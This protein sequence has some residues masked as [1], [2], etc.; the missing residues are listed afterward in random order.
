MSFSRRDRIIHKSLSVVNAALNRSILSRVTNRN[1]GT[2]R[3]AW[4]RSPEKY[5]ANIGDALSAVM[6]TA[7]SGRLC[8]KEP[9]RSARERLYAV[10]TIAHNAYG[11]TA[12]I[13]GTGLDAKF[14]AFDKTLGRYAAPPSTNVRVHATRGPYSRQAFVDAAIP[15]PRVYGDPV[16][17]LPSIFPA[18][19][20]KKWDLGVIVHVTEL[21]A[22]SPED[23]TRPD[24]IR[25]QIPPEFRDRVKIISTV[26]EPT[27]DAMMAKMEEITSC[28][29]ILSVSLHGL[30]FA[31]SYGIPCLYFGFNG[32]NACETFDLALATEDV[33]NHRVRDLYAG[34]GRDKITVYGCDRIR[35]TDWAAAMSAIDE[36]WSPAQFDP[37]PLLDAFPLPLAFDPRRGEPFRNYDLLR[38]IEF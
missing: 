27:V 9:F 21:A 20:E 30:V 23:K 37:G 14:N 6:V 22:F 11:G 38:Q 5:Y 15:A 25:Y 1:D 28:R 13:W 16:W 32:P 12:H 31:E 10:G 7:L 34:L 18:A 17:M 19:T 26:V 35:P 4:A 29:R 3:L 2:I 8:R 36:V 24:F 33:L